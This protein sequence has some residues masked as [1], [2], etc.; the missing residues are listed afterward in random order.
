MFLLER[1][2]K[3]TKVPL[4]YAIKVMAEQMGM[5]PSTIATSWGLK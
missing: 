5:S 1:L 2:P 4:D 3:M